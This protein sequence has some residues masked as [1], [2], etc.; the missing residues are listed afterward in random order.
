M[1]LKSINSFLQCH[2]WTKTLK[3]SVEHSSNVSTV[4]KSD[5]KFWKSKLFRWSTISWRMNVVAPSFMSNLLDHVYCIGQ[6]S[7]WRKWL[8][9]TWKEYAHMYNFNTGLLKGTFNYLHNISEP[10]VRRPSGY[11][12]KHC[13]KSLLKKDF[14]AFLS[15]FAHFSTA[16]YTFLPL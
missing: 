9:W 5:K 3:F 4:G 13:S 1:L 12:A 10:V 7:P 15:S 11:S 8:G 14:I 2:F 16:T 6:C